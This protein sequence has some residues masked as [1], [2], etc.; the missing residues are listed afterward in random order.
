VLYFGR[1]SLWCWKLDTSES[2]WEIPGKFWSVVLEKDE[3]NQVDRS[4]EKW[5]SITQ[6]QEGEE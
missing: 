6:S 4:C 5:G 2:I 3:E 1:S